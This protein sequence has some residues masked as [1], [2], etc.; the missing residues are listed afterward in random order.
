MG[1]FDKMSLKHM[2]RYLVEL[3]WRFNNRENPHIF[4]DTLARIVR[5]RPMH[6]RELVA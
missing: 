2:D 3:E 1:T 6:Y 5:A 4:R